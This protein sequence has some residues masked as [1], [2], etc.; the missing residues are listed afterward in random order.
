MVRVCRSGTRFRVSAR[1]GE[2]LCRE[3]PHLTI[4]NRYPA[5]MA[6]GETRPAVTARP[7]RLT[8]YEIADLVDMT[9]RNIR[10]HQTRGLLPP[11]QMH[12]RVAYYDSRHVARLRLI[13]A[14]QKQGFTLTSIATMLQNPADYAGMLRAGRRRT[15]QTIYDQAWVALTPDL[16]DAL[17]QLPERYVTDLEAAGLMERTDGGWMTHPT[18][19]AGV[20]ALLDS[21]IPSRTIGAMAVM[22]A[23]LA[24]VAGEA[25]DHLLQA[26][27]EEATRLAT[28][29]IIETVSTAFEVAVRHTLVVASE[30]GG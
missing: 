21:G 20:S 16:L 8:L 2:A 26:V 10:A 13:K 18:L 19:V 11:P 30:P 23:N 28:P 4:K 17:N 6:G 27:D 15:A 1:L 14:L 12:G 25:L 24:R 9:P 22:I 29:L 5:G 3:T 7:P